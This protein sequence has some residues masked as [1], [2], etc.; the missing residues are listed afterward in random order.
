MKNRIITIGIALVMAAGYSACKKDEVKPASANTQA[1]SDPMTSGTWKVA[2]YEV[3]GVEHTNIYTPYAL[4]FRSYGNL[5]ASGSGKKVNGTWSAN[6]VDGGEGMQ[7]DFGTNDPFSLLNSAAWKVV[8]KTA[9]K[10]EMKGKRGDDGEH[11][12]TLMKN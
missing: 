5:E 12:L 1:S 2:R 10:V 7:L 9:T 4:A 8:S 3:N 11:S 6:A